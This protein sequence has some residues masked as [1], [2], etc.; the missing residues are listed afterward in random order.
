MA[1][2]KKPAARIQEANLLGL[3]A[4]SCAGAE[5]V[6]RIILERP[7]VPPEKRLWVRGEDDMRDQII[8]LYDEVQEE[9]SRR[10]QAEEIELIETTTSECLNE[11]ESPEIDTETAARHLWW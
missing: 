10:V 6:H 8:N 11:Q 3:R 9:L 5:W 4:L 2:K 1:K 7:E